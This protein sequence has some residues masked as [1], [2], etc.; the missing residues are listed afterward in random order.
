M[1]H[2]I[3]NT[4][5]GMLHDTPLTILLP[6]VFFLSHINHSPLMYHHYN[7]E[8]VLCFHHGEAF[9]INYPVIT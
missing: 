9:I 5:D 2:K 4:S 7:E 6:D 8:Y 3:W 1:T